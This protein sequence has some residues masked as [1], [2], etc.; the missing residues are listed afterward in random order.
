MRAALESIYH[1]VDTSL[2]DA[3]AFESS[4]FGLLASTEDMKEGTA[5]DVATLA[6]QYVLDVDRFEGG[7]GRLPVLV[8]KTSKTPIAQ[9]FSCI[10][11]FTAANRIK[12]YW[13]VCSEFP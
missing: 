4:L 7:P 10:V 5:A 2:T 1:G 6:L 13:P 9:L 3:L 12:T 11:S 8:V